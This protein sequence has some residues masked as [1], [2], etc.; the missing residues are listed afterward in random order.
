LPAFVLKDIKA[1]ASIQHHVNV[2]DEHGTYASLVENAG[3]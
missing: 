3:Y 2:L 1:S